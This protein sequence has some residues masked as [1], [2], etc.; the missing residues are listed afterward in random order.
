MLHF[1]YVILSGTDLNC[2][3]GHPKQICGQLFNQHP[4]LM[5]IVYHTAGNN[6]NS[7]FV[8]RGIT[9]RFLADEKKIQNCQGFLNLINSGSSVE[10]PLKKKYI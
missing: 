1:G 5:W 3:A 10:Y 7:A 8:S 6:S 4:L 9:N 2:I